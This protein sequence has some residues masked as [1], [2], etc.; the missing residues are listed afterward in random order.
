MK[1]EYNSELSPIHYIDGIIFI[2]NSLIYDRFALKSR[3]ADLSK[4]I[5]SNLW[6]STMTIFT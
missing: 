3:I 6:D 4:L 2:H 5:G 1:S